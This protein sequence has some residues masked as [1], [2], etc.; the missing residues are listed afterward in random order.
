MDAKGTG[1]TKKM[2]VP[3]LGATTC[4]S[5]CHWDIS[6]MVSMFSG[7]GAGHHRAVRGGAGAAAAHPVPRPLR[8]L[9]ARCEPHP[10]GRHAHVTQA[11]DTTHTQE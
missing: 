10:G 9:P 6:H 8:V 5:I 3:L 2:T 4:K 11:E 7:V 1:F